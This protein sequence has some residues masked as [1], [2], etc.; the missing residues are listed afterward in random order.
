[1]AASDSRSIVITLKLEGSEGQGNNPTDTQETSNNSDNNRTAKA[2]AVF[3]VGK[4]IEIAVS[5]V[6]AWADYNWNKEL[7]LNDDYIGQRNKNIAL[8][9]I[10]RAVSAISTVGSSIAAGAMVGGVPGAIIGGVLGVAKVFSSTI[11]GNV[12]GQEQQNIMIRQMDAQL[13]F[14]RSRAGWSTRA[15]SIGEDL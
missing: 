12:Q 15:G 11:R 8:M 14:T 4:A 5:E 13:E 10:N 1:M 3:A 9:Q 7:T 6:V 2:L